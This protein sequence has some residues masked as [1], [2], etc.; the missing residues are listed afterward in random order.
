[1]LC[2]TSA[3]ALGEICLE[4]PYLVWLWE[5]G[6]GEWASSLYVNRDVRLRKMIEIWSYSFV[7]WLLRATDEIFD[8]YGDVPYG[9]RG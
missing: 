6:A 1:M 2:H 3:N 8:S 9:V 5:S 4:V 7:L